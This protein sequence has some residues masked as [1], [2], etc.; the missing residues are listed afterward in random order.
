MLIFVLNGHHFMSVRQT[1][2]TVSCMIP[3][4]VVLL[5]C[6]DRRIDAYGRHVNMRQSEAS[7]ERELRTGIK[8]SAPGFVSA[9]FDVRAMIPLSE[10][11][12]T[13]ELLERLHHDADECR[14]LAE[15]ALTAESR[16]V[17]NDMAQD[18]EK[19]ATMLKVA[20]RRSL[21]IR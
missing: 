15:T 13:R 8:V 14:N 9:Q 4:C 5:F 7:L 18:F 19:R 11:G 10:F 16:A 2:P 21:E 17:L 20:G 1:K 3:K 6:L 12:M